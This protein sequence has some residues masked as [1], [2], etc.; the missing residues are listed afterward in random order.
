[1]FFQAEMALQSDGFVEIDY[2]TLV[3]VLSRETLNCREVV[4]FEAALAW[5]EA[6]C[7][8]RELP[9]TPEDKRKVRRFP[10][11]AIWIENLIKL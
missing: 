6:E 1:M 11:L 10:S 9:V 3:L 2:S 5:A 7:A 8:R 4:L